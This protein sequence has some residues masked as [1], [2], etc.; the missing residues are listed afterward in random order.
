MKKLTTAVLF[1][2]AGFLMFSSCS[3]TEGEPP[4]LPRNYVKFAVQGTRINGNFE[5]E[6]KDYADDANI[7][8]HHIPEELGDMV[9][10]NVVDFIQGVGFGLVAPASEK[11]TEILLDNPSDY[12]LTLLF[13]AGELEAKTVSLHMTS[14]QLGTGSVTVKRMKG[15]FEGVS[16]IREEEDE[17][18]VKIEEVHTVKGE[19]E[20]NA[21]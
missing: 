10:L 4:T 12:R 5:I 16:V 18:G 9:A 7:V 19:F 15:N 1:A 6:K 13:E 20:Y 2:F 21:L 11:M 8:A 3:K 14:L 17:N